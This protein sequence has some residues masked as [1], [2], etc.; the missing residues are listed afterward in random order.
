MN[1]YIRELNPSPLRYRF[2]GLP[3]GLTGQLGAEFI[4][5]GHIFTTTQ[6]VFI[7]VHQPQCTYMMFIYLQ[8]CNNADDGH[9]K[10]FFIQLILIKNDGH[11]NPLP[12]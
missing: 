3:T 9:E 12:H 4:F 5:S 7:T 2:S 1:G 10:V 11:Q 6:A 8:S